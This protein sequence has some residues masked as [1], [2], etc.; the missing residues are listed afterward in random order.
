M[1]NY[2]LFSSTMNMKRGEDLITMIEELKNFLTY[3]KLVESSSQFPDASMAVLLI[4]RRGSLR[5][6]RNA[7]DGFLNLLEHIVS[8]GPRGSHIW[9]TQKRLRSCVQH[10]GVFLESPACSCHL[11][12]TLRVFQFLR[13]HKDNF[14]TLYTVKMKPCIIR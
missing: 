14:T 7:S 8:I 12:S 10:G 13:N 3:I 1:I 2:H 6:A 5:R 4:S 11:I 9:V